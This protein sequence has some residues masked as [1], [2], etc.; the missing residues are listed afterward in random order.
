MS[1]ILVTGS[2]GLLADKLI[3]EFSDFDVFAGYYNNI[4]HA[5]KKIKID[6]TD[7]KNVISVI[8]KIQPD[9][10][11]H[12]AAL[13]NVDLCEINRKGAWKINV[14]GTRNITEAIKGKN[15]KIVLISTDFVFDGKKGLYSEEDEPNPIN[16]YGLTKLEAERLVKKHDN[17]LIIRTARIFGISKYKDNFLIFVIKKLRKNEEIKIVGDQYGSPTLAND[18][19]RIIKQLIKK[20]ARGLYNVVG[21]DTISMYEFALKIAKVF[22]LN[23]HLIK[24]IK[25]KELQQKALRPMKCGLKT[26]KIKKLGIKTLGI[27]EALIKIK[28]EIEL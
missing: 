2:A 5:K 15:I 25:S 8:K 21:S 11:I 17:Y 1:C 13:T 18:I 3:N 6:I 12:A 26:D 10:I 9:I 14:Q 24:K 28:N 4:P 20:N 19:S 16:Y 7:K 23:A 27:E 22:N